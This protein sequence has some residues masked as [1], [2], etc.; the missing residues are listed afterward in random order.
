MLSGKL[1]KQG[2]QLTAAM[3]PMAQQLVGRI[4][5]RSSNNCKDGPGVSKRKGR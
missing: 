5:D 4:S 3:K 1:R 2:A